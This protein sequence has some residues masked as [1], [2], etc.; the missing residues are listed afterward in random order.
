MNIYFADCDGNFLRVDKEVYDLVQNQEIVVFIKKDVNMIFTGNV[1]EIFA[2]CHHDPRIIVKIDNALEK[3]I[4]SSASVADTFCSEYMDKWKDQE[5][6]TELYHIVDKMYGVP[7]T[8]EQVDA[9]EVG[10]T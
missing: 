8:R 4:Y 10:T 5:N 9:D 7:I 3:L 6:W 1:M 2:N